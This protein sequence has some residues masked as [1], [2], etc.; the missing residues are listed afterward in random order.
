MPQASRQ[1]NAPTGCDNTTAGHGRPHDNNSAGNAG[2]GV[3]TVADNWETG[4]G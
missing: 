1:K 4:S 2:T 3:L